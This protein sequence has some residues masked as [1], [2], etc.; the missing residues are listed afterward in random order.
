MM[1]VFI[2]MN[3]GLV[4]LAAPQ[5]NLPPIAFNTLSFAFMFFLPE[6]R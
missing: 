5:L 2:F 6:R 3:V 1:T 4:A